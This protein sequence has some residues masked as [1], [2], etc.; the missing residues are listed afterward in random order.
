[1]NLTKYIIEIIELR[2]LSS[3]YFL[4]N[5]AGKNP[6]TRILSL[7][8]MPSILHIYLLFYHHPHHFLQ[9]N[10]LAL[11]FVFY[12]RPEGAGNVGMASS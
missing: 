9:D 7:I 5:R 11:S 10:N 1:M 2:V 4:G 12:S 3:I 6:N 8:T